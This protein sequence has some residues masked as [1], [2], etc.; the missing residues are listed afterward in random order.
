MPFRL[1]HGSGSQPP[2]QLP[3]PPPQVYTKGSPEKL[4]TFLEANSVPMDYADT[5]QVPYYFLLSSSGF[6]KFGCV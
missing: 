5:L 4:I 3:N 6:K 2:R 1:Q